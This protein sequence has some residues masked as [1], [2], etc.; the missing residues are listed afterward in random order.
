MTAPFSYVEKTIKEHGVEAARELFVFLANQVYAMKAV[1]EKEKLDCDAVVTRYVETFLEQS[2]ADRV[3]KTYEEA[4][5][6]ELDFIQDVDH[7][8]EKYV[9]T[10]RNLIIFSFNNSYGQLLKQNSY[11]ESKMQ[12]EVLQPRPCSYGLTNSSPAYLRD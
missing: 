12:K 9:E 1:V 7:F 6:A 3:K 5:T 11:R 4:L 8:G 2:H 10:V